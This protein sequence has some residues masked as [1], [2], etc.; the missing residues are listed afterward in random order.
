MGNSAMNCHLYTKY[1]EDD[2][3][4]LKKHAKEGYIINIK[5]SNWTSY[6]NVN[7]DGDIE[8][9]RNTA[10]KLSKELSATAIVF[11]IYDS[12]I[13]S[14]YLI[15]DGELI[16]YY[17]SNPNYFDNGDAEI[18]P[19]ENA[20]K[21]CEIL[22][23]PEKLEKVSEILGENEYVFE[24]ERVEEFAEILGINQVVATCG[25]DDIEDIEEYLEEDFYGEVEVIEIE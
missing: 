3:E 16:D 24:D 23:I 15:K 8:K 13:F 17:C 25:H 18:N 2:Y 10:I 1:K 14:Y 22:G 7:E 9:L 19:G 6:Y 4:K 11:D 12:D 20:N 21:L 5:D